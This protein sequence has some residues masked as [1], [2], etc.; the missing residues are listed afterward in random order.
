MRLLH[1]AHIDAF[2]RLDLGG[3]VAQALEDKLR[4]VEAAQVGLADVKQVAQAH[5][6]DQVGQQ[7]VD[8]ITD[9]DLQLAGTQ[10]ADG[11]LGGLKQQ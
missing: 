9:A 6:A 5:A 3:I 10:H 4:A 2:R 8:G 7:A 1:P 11:L